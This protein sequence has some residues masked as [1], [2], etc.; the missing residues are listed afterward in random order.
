ML[1]SLCGYKLNGL[2]NC[3][4]P[5]LTQKMFENRSRVAIAYLCVIA[6][7]HQNTRS[8]VSTNELR[9]ITMPSCSPGSRLNMY[10][11][12]YR[13]NDSRVYQV[14]VFFNTWY[15]ITSHHTLEPTPYMH[16]RSRWASPPPLS[17]LSLSGSYSPAVNYTLECG[18]LLNWVFSLCPCER[19]FRT[20][21]LPS[22]EQ[23]IVLLTVASPAVQHTSP[24][25][26]RVFTPNSRR[27]LVSLLRRA[28]K[29][30][31]LFSK[32]LLLFISF[33]CGRMQWFERVC[34][35]WTRANWRCAYLL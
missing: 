18:S 10:L 29:S 7:D 23:F 15:F 1:P 16:F 5:S 13:E 22:A 2:K 24:A 3:T 35:N 30:V 27:S 12:I 17:P 25:W 14:A 26:S 21:F 11:Y 19:S 33:V 4:A 8:F 6:D 9:H 20:F 31:F 34:D 32:L 28:L